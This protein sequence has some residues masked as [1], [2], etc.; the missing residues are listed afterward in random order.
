MLKL[1]KRQ[2]N[3]YRDYPLQAVAVLS[4]IDSAQQAGFSLEEIKQ[5][6]PEDFSSWQHEDLM[7]VLKKKVADIE[8]KP[9]CLA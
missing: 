1:G 6:M 7:T 4:I 9:T 2:F 3:G 5:V 8:T